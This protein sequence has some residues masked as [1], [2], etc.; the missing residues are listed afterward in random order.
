MVTQLYRHTRGRLEEDGERPGLLELEAEF[1]ASGYRFRE[2]L[3]ALITSELFRTVA[4]Q[5]AE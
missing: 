4:P 2:L 5:E 3:L 1:E